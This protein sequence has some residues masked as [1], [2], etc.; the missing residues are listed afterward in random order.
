M[1]GEKLTK[2]D[3]IDSVYLKSGMNRL[4]VRA[5]YD[6][7]FT[8]IKGALAGGRTVE[9]RGV[10]TFEVRVRK[11]RKVAR[12]PRTGEAVPAPPHR[13]V[14]FRPGQ[15]LKLSVWKIQDAPDPDAGKKE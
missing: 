12:N 8:E 11:G 7:I 15:E 13:V 10:G 5:I 1:R 4:N 6:L 9:L 2:A 14:A 3:I